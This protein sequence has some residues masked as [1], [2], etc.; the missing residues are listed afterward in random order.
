MADEIRDATPEEVANEEAIK[1]FEA[2]AAFRQS[3][4]LPL[5]SAMNEG[6]FYGLL[7][8]GGGPLSVV[9]R[10]GFALIGIT[11]AGSAFLEI[12]LTFPSLLARFGL[13][14]AEFG[15]AP[16]Y[17]IVWLPFEAILFAGGIWL[18]AKAL[19]PRRPRVE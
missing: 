10:I 4:V 8:R 16:S 6:R 2:E 14:R 13:P 11:M 5:D 7:V 19:W 3:N 17:A 9:Q 18:I 1:H 12:C 15:A